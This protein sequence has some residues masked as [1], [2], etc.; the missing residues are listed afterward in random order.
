VSITD[1]QILAAYGPPCSGE[2]L[3]ITLNGGGRVVVQP[4]FADAVMA[5][6][7]CLRA[8][9][10]AARAADTG[11]YACRKKRLLSG[12]FSDSWS[13]HA[14]K[15][16]IDLNWQTNPFTKGRLITDY[17]PEMILDIE[18]IRT[19]SGATPWAWGG[20]WKSSKDAM[21]WQ[22]GC[23]PRDLAS[24][25]DPRTVPGAPAFVEPDPES[26][27]D[28]EMAKPPM[29]V[30]V[31]ESPD[32]QRPGRKKGQQ[33]YRVT[34]D[35]FAVRLTGAEWERVRN[36]HTLAGVPFTP[37]VVTHDAWR[38][39]AVGLVDPATRKKVVS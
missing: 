5:F 27:E 39:L 35:T 30:L 28:D 25:I 18:G 14:I 33:L 13:T 21:H 37:S 3:R 17:P 8:H 15:G 10:Y 9:G 16:T 22:P 31:K 26:E 2:S 34:L 29:Y 36:T 6:D 4:I 32:P 1:A 11:G 20:R 7:A 19:V 12:G 24:G 38:N 23:L